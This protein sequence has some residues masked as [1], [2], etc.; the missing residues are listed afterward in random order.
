MVV[1][2]VQWVSEPCELQGPIPYEDPDLPGIP[3][4]QVTVWWTLQST[5]ID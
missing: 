3:R 2:G 4:Y 5:I 1:D